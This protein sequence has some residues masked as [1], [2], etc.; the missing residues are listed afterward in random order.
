[1][2]D[3]E[4]ELDQEWADDQEDA[5]GDDGDGEGEGDEADGAEASAEGEGAPR[6]RRRARG[7]GEPDYLPED[8]ERAMQALEF[9]A[10]VVKEMEMDCRVRL[11]RPKDDDESPEISIE[12][13]GPDA[14]R[15]I[16]KKGQVLM[17][18]QFLTHRVVNRSGLEKRHVLVDAEG[19]RSRR[20]NSLA[21][22]ARRL[23][24]QAVE[25]G[26]IIT[27]EPMNP[28]DRRVVHLALA[29][30]E[31]VVTKSDGEGASRRV[32]IIPVRRTTTA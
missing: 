3:S 9:V 21:S 20:D 6:R 10:Q 32:Q 28:R 18:L 2:S 26:K 12:I 7:N 8:D 22:M 17:A 11:R 23:G 25:Q 19:Y 5:D 29:K 30:F 16:G 24:K 31:G 27:F 13:A 15:I 14:G 1:M 4:Q